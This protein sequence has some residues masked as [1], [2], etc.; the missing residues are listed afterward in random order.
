MTDIAQ[1]TQ[2]IQSEPQVQ[3]AHPTETTSQPQSNYTF[4]QVIRVPIV[5]E[6]TV[7][8]QE[9]RDYYLDAHTG[10]LPVGV[11]ADMLDTFEVERIG[12]E[13][14]LT[15]NNMTHSQAQAALKA[16]EGV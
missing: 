5:L 3:V 4:P 8:N 13:T 12:S 14:L 16:A 6:I 9:E 10:A 1:A 15:V 2:T 11:I 7:N